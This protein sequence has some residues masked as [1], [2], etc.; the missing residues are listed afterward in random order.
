MSEMIESTETSEEVVVANITPY[1]AAKVANKI[2][3]LRGFDT[4]ITPQMF[5]TY[6]KKGT[7]KTTEVGGK[8]YFIG[9]EFKSWLTQ[10]IERK[11]SGEQ[12]SRVNIDD[13][14]TQYM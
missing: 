6:A 1:Y 4:K 14:S 2:L 3:E 10:Y 5:Y 8:T 9:S 11:E 13:L 12:M 7:I